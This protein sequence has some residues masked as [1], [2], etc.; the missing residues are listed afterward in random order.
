MLMSSLDV[1]TDVLT[2]KYSVETDFSVLLIRNIL[3]IILFIYI[4][5]INI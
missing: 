4:N 5:S 1:A 2:V 3:M